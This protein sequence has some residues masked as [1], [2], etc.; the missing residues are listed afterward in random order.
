MWRIKNFEKY[1]VFYVPLD[2]G[3]RILHVIHS[4]VD[5]NRVFEDE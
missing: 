5:Y 4:A 1:L 2:R 3:V